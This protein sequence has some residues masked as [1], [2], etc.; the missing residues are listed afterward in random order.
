[1]AANKTNGTSGQRSASGKPPV[2][3]VLQLSGGNDFMS[4]VVPYG[5]PHYYDFRKT[6]GIK[7][8]DVLRVDGRIGFHPAL[9]TLKSMYDQGQVAIIQGI[10]YPNPDRSH[11]RSMDIWHTAEPSK[12]VADGWLGKAIHDLDPQKQNVCTG[13]SFGQGLPRAMYF[14]GTPV[15]SVAHLESYGLLTTLSGREQRAALNAFTRMYAPEEFGEAS[16]VLGHIGQTGR[17]AMTGADMLKVAPQK[18]QSSVEYASDTLAQSLRGIAQVHLSGV[19]T[20]V[21]YA[22][23]GGYDVHGSQIQ[24]QPKLL[25][26]VS[27]AVNDFFADLRDH[28]AAENVVMLIFSE[29]GRRVRDNGNGTDHGS[30]GGAFLLGER[31]R[32]GLY[33]EYPSLAPERQSSGDLAY[34]NDFRVLYSTILEQWMGLDA[35]PIVNGT[36]EQFDGLLKPAAA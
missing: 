34:N 25:G 13:V 7:E 35:V 9:K 26:Q 20:R 33:A 24:T 17:D 29:F 14:S 8:A 16:L 11:F 2:L 30:G 32:G 21:F 23:H 6:V 36:F 19:G 10:G 18:Y 3:V 31:V 15:I 12:I 1:M 4:T 27:R 5:D 22:Q 28:D